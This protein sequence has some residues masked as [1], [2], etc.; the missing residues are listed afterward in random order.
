MKIAVKVE[1]LRNL[2]SSIG[3]EFGWHY[4]LDLTWILQNLESIQ[5]QFIMDAGAGRVFCS[6]TWLPKALKCLV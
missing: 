2:A 5:G 4:L 3:L 6:G 1:E